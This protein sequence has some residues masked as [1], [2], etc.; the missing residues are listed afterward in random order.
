MLEIPRSSEIPT[1][2]RKSSVSIWQYALCL[3]TCLWH[4]AGP[5]SERLAKIWRK[6]CENR[7]VPRDGFC[8]LVCFFSVVPPRNTIVWIVMEERKVL[9]CW[10]LCVRSYSDVNQGLSKYL[11]HC[12]HKVLIIYVFWNIL[13]PCSFLDVLLL[14]EGMCGEERDI[15]MNDLL[16]YI[17]S[18]LF[19]II[20]IPVYLSTLSALCCSRPWW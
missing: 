2:R 13:F 3:V 20:I 16:M 10:W 9:L 1:G 8:L 17:C 12:N 19:I 7:K 14:L 5:K 11:G 18:V 6:G 4:A 15:H